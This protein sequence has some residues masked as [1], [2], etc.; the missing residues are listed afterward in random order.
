MSIITQLLGGKITWSQAEAEAESWFAKIAGAAPAGAVADAGAALSDLK[1]AASD[2]LGLADTALG[3]I[4]AVG[5]AAV[6]TAANTALV[7]AIGPGATSITP[8][9]DAAL[10]A[11]SNALKAEIDAVEAQLRAKIVG[12]APATQVPF[13]QP[14]LKTV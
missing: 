8:A 5:T 13:V 9:M 14:A 11:G 3:P 7:A 12:G 1:Q 6:E 2:A 4:F 10:T